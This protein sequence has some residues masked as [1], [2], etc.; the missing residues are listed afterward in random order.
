MTRVDIPRLALPD[1]VMTP[2]LDAATVAELFG[3]SYRA[4][5]D[6]GRRYVETNGE[7]GLPAIKIGRST[8]FLTARCLHLLGVAE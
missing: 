4:A 5:Y 2:T 3:I 6:A 8:R 1:P 7:E